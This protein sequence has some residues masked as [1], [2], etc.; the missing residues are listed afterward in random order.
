MSNFAHEIKTPMTAILGFA[1]TLR[2]YDCDVDTKKKCADYIYT[3]G[4]RLE[5][6]SYTLMDL[7]SLSGKD[8]QLQPVSIAS[9]V[10]QL[11]QY[12][13]A[14]SITD[15]L[16]FHCASCTVYALEELLF[17]ALRNLIDNA[18]KASDADQEILVK[19]ELCGK[20]Y[21]ISVT[22]H[23]IGMRKDDIQQASQPFY[24]ADK[25]RARQQGG[26]G[27]GLSIVKRICDLHG[28]PLLITSQL[29]CLVS[30]RLQSVCIAAAGYLLHPGQR[31]S[32]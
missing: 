11:R 5:K 2:T 9:V 4:K 13:D 3:E 10:K 1:D 8:I 21:R 30:G 27:L 6:L 31:C 7:L 16:C 29:H 24:M 22:D 12:Y 15:R 19:G 20:S 14:V 32:G 23:G 28:S 25:S 18:I 26:A 17:S